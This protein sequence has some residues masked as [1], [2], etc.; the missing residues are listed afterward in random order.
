MAGIT[1]NIEGRDVRGDDG[2]TILEVCQKNDI[3]VPTLCHFEG[4]TDIGSC[5]MCIVDIDN[6][7]KSSIDTACTTPAAEGIKVKVNTERLME[8]RKAT[9]ELLFAEGN[10]YCMYCVSSGNCELQDL[11]YEFGIDHIRWPGRHPRRQMDSSHKYLVMDYDRCILC[12]RCIRACDELVGNNT[13]GIEGRGFRAKIVADY[14]VPWGESSCINAG[15]CLQV[16][17]TGAISDRRSAYMGRDEQIQQTKSTCMF[18][19]VGCGIDILTRDNQI[20]RINGDWDAMP[21]KGLLCQLGRF[22]PLYEERYHRVFSPMIKRGDKLEEAAWDDVLDLLAGKIKEFDKGSIGGLAST[23]ATNEEMS[24]F[25]SMFDE[26]GVSNLGCMIGAI[27]KPF[28]DEVDL[29][30]LNE[31]D[32]FIV[33]GEDLAEDHQVVGFFVKRGVSKRWSLLLAVSEEETKLSSL[34]NLWL[35]PDEIKEAVRHSRAAANPAVI[36]GSRAGKEMEL[37]RHELSSRASFYWMPPGANS[38]G[39]L[40]TGLGKEL[41]F[42]SAKFVYVLACDERDVSEEL[43]NQ[44]RDVDFV[45]VHSSYMDPWKQVAD[46]ILPATIWSE[47][48]GSTTNLEG[49]TLKVNRAVI[50]PLGVKPNTEVLN[51][52]MEKLGMLTL[53]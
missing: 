29:S 42:D 43:L 4:L 40:A 7:G 45:V 11:A 6:A 24:H 13:L 31:A 27:N 9:L 15:A 51:L 3:H 49:K 16:C 41:N 2:D 39:A 35:K 22:G 23:R 48:D 17:P 8:M 25:L 21:N 36:Y 26:M 10:H 28:D 12:Y 50:P 19:S 30:R 44:L 52:L 14:N 34:S 47:K 53:T 38:L 1:L 20:I 5:R 46:I 37:L 33:V 32:M 18:C